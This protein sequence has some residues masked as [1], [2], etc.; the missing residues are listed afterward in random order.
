MNLLDAHAATN[1]DPALLS[2]VRALVE[3]QQA[4]LA[5]KDFKITAL[6]HELAYYPRVRFVKASEAF[7]GEQRLLF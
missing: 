4:K 2:Q 5:E 1:L 7:V 6:T 3:Q